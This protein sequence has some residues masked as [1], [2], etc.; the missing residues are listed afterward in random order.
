MKITTFI[1]LISIFYT[2]LSC[3]KSDIAKGTP[4]C[5]RSKIELIQEEEVRNPPAE[6][7]KYD[8]KGMEVYYIT[9]Y[10]CDIPSE[11]YDSDCNLICHPDGGITGNGDGQCTD[12]AS[13]R[14]NGSLV[15]KDSR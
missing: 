13:E 14:S 2:I 15:W 1:F 12:F 8:Y 9:A 11:L 5:I 3:E 6:I 10:C 7:W 4:D